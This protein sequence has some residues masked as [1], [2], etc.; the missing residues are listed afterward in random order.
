MLNDWLETV[1]TNLRS[2]RK[3]GKNAVDSLLEMTEQMHGAFQLADGRLP[4]FLEFWTQA[5][6]NPE[7]W[8]AT[9]QPYHRYQQFF[10]GLVREGIAD[11]SL[12]PVDPEAAA[13]TIVSMA[14]GLFLQGVLDPA[15]ASWNEAAAQSM[16]LLLKSMAKREQ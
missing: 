16:R 7:V 11:G 1:D 15:G 6:H 4:K 3:E 13:R 14:V 8:E 5:S 10:A 9:I 12:S 2:V